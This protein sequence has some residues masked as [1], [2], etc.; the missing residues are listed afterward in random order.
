MVC[1]ARI[2][3]YAREPRKKHARSR[4]SRRCCVGVTRSPVGEND[5][6]R[7]QAPQHAHNL[8]HSR[9]CFQSPRR[10]VERAAPATPRI[11]A[12]S[13]A[14]RSRSSAVPRVP[15]S[16]RVRSRIAVRAPAKP[17]AKASHRRSVPRHRDAPLWPARRTWPQLQSMRLPSAP[18]SSSE[19][20][21]G[22]V[23]VG[24]SIHVGHVVAV[25]VTVTN[26]LLIEVPSTV[27]KIYTC[28][29]SAV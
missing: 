19:S 13:F 17:C 29:P 22:V 7:P 2:G 28:P 9:A 5:D 23:G 26:W 27:E 21:H 16:P 24:Q 1:A 6:P 12:A 14:S 20:V 25:P 4:A 15:P 3:L 18:Q 8:L 10:Q 11:P